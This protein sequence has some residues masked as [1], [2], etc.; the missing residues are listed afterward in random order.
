MEKITNKLAILAHE[1]ELKTC[2]N[3]TDINIH[4][5]FFFCDLLNLIY[6]FELINANTITS[7]AKA[8]DL[9]DF[10]KR[11]AVQVTS[12][13]DFQKIKHTID[14][15]VL[16]ENA[17]KIDRLKILIL[18]KKKKYKALT[19]GDSF[20]IQIKDD[21]WDY[22]D[23][24]KTISALPP[25]KIKNIYDY[26]ESQLPEIKNNKAPKEVS[27]IL[28]MIK[29]LSTED[30]PMSGNGFLDEPDPHKK[31][32]TRFSAYADYLLG[33]YVSL[34]STYAG[35]LAEISSQS[36]AGILNLNKIAVYLKRFSDSTLNECDGDPVKALNKMTDY[37]AAKLIA[38]GIDYD[39]SAI[40][41]Y[42]IDNMIRCNVFPNKASLPC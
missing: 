17:N 5:E 16:S 7:N 22:T 30:H 3:L 24:I 18:T 36:D 32:N 31:I 35:I 13:S 41:Y 37:Y 2:L 28:G 4:A 6:G 11:I 34:I 29:I 21:V 42:L 40:Q 23:L 25:E 15:F 9:V 39:D 26:L 19:Y 33:I 14:G 1:V 12:T 27:T 10:N 20:K 8:I 38:D